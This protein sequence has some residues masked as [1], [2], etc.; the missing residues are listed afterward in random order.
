MASELKGRYTD[1]YRGDK[2]AG[3]VVSKVRL[4]LNQVKVNFGADIA[5]ELVAKKRYDL[6]N[7]HWLELI[8]LPDEKSADETAKAELKRDVVKALYLDLHESYTSLTY[9]WL[10]AEADRLIAGGTPTGGPS[11]FLNDYLI[12]CGLLNAEV[13]I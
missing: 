3:T 8:L 5:R 7:T 9:T 13:A 10:L 11:M 12:K 6:G 4:S 1:Y 2:A